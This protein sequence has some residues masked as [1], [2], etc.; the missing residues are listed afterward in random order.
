MK[1]ARHLFRVYSIEKVG[2]FSFVFFV[3]FFFCSSSSWTL[4]CFLFN[5]LVSDFPK[6]NSCWGHFTSEPIIRAMLQSFFHFQDIISY[7]DCIFPSKLFITCA[8]PKGV[9]LCQ[10]DNY[11][12]G[13]YVCQHLNEMWITFVLF[14]ELL[15]LFDVK[16]SFPL[17]RSI[18][19]W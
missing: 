1:R 3:C 10:A 14:V 13:I 12:R 6:K 2:I 5:L 8:I 9:L 4:I 15:W 18:G 16:L 17:L 7:K 11:V 19:L